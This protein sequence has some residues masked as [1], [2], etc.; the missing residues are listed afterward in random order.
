[1]SHLSFD[2]ADICQHTIDVPKR[3]SLT[4]SE[5]DLV[6]ALWKL[7]EGTVPQL[8]SELNSQKGREPI[9]RGT[10]QVLL[11]RIEA[12]GWVERKKSGRAYLYRATTEEHGG[13]AEWAGE[14]Q[15]KFFDGSALQLVQ[16][17]V[18]SKKLNRSE[19][20]ELRGLLDEAEKKL[21]SK[22][23]TKSKR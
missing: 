20:D 1:M 18:H 19:I 9:T 13:L 6:K 21:N 10:V 3:A 8:V 16:S 4:K 23:S 12:K 7:G 15:T 22:S 11:N 5:K 17:L 14:F 2:N